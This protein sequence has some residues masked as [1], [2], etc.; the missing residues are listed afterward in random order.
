M[1]STCHEDGAGRGKGVDGR[2]DRHCFRGGHNPGRV[3]AWSVY[4]YHE[5]AGRPPRAADRFTAS[6]QLAGNLET[7]KPEK[8]STTAHGV[9]VALNG[10]GATD[11]SSAGGR[12]SGRRETGSDE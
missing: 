9:A 11:T 12:V 6:V 5:R 1:G 8:T 10:H 3:A 4:L 2:G 7:A